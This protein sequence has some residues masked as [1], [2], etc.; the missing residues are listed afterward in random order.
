MEGSMPEREGASLALCVSEFGLWIIDDGLSLLTTH[1]KG[2]R[3]IAYVERLEETVYLLS[4][5]LSCFGSARVDP[6]FVT[7]SSHESISVNAGLDY[8]RET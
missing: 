5:G 3:R 6:H 1:R 8:T 4:R 2:K 7:A